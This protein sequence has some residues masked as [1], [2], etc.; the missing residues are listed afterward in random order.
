MKNSVTVSSSNLMYWVVIAVVNAFLIGILVFHRNVLVIIPGIAL[1][2]SLTMLIHE[3]MKNENKMTQLSSELEKL[4]ENEE[5][6]DD[7]E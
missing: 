7:D 5:Q 2:I 4:K 3:I 6:E 1:I